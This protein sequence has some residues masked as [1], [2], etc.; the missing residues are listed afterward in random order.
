MNPAILSKIF[1]LIT[2]STFNDVDVILKPTF[3]E[4][5]EFYI[6][7]REYFILYYNNKSDNLS[8]EIPLKI[9][10]LYI[11]NSKVKNFLDSIK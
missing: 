5:D 9:Q 3:R 10:K 1:L 6:L 8:L 11:N 7:I 4:T 2:K